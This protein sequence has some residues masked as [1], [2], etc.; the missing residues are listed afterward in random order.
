[1]D[2][3]TKRKYRLHVAVALVMAAFAMLSP[4]GASAQT[5]PQMTQY[6]AMPALY[7][8]AAT[9]TTDFLRIRGGARLQW[10]GIDNAPKSFLVVADSPLK[11]GKKRIGLGLNMMSES[12]GLFSNLM[13]N[14][15]GSYKFKLFK[16]E[17]SIGLQGGYFNQKFKGSE[18]V[19]P[20]GDDYHDPSD[21]GIPTQDLNGSAFDFSAGIFYS[22][23]KF[24]FGMAGLH[25]LQ[26][27]VSM[28]LEGS[29]STD[30]QT[31][32]TQMG[33]MIYFI[34]GGNFAI[35]NTLFELQPS[36]LVK[37]DF[38]M[39]SAEATVRARYNKFLSFGLAYRWKEAVSVMVGAEIKN[40]FLG[41]SYDY[42]LSAIGKVSSGSHE[43]VA[44]YQLKIDFSGKNRNKHRSIRIM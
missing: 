35:K 40:F 36:M 13:L 5:D 8:P 11:I 9:G 14:I 30:T 27:T 24:W 37:S 7:N 12:L 6:W 41:Y 16:G 42:P 2:N 31:F 34:G 10:V 43:L 3:T 25:L 21:E 17:L 18:V 29:E 33:R 44:G 23:P 20:G 4:C 26:P 32:E 1:M 15:Q 38:K 22:K 19:V 28:N 39:F